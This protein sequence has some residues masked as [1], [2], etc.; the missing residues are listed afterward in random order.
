MQ[1]RAEAAPVARIATSYVPDEFWLYVARLATER[2]IRIAI[3]EVAHS[4]EMRAVKHTRLYA[5]HEKLRQV[6]ATENAI[7]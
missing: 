3:D 1:L 5:L 6:H 2:E 7:P 4:K